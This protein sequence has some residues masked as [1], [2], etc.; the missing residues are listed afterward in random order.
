MLQRGEG[1]PTPSSVTEANYK[2]RRV[3]GGPPPFCTVT[4]SSGKFR[5]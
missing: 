4:P 5:Q 3:A 2:A 1:G